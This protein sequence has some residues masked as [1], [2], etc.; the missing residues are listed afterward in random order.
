MGE[1]ALVDEQRLH[2]M[3]KDEE[4]RLKSV[5]VKWEKEKVL[6]EMGNL[7]PMILDNVMLN[8]SFYQKSK[9][10]KLK[11]LLRLGVPME[12][13]GKIWG[14][15]LHVSSIEAYNR[16]YAAGVRRYY[17]E[18]PPEH[19]IKHGL[20]GGKINHNLPLTPAGYRTAEM[21]LG[22]LEGDIHGLNYAPCLP[23][24]VVLLLHF[25]SPSETLGICLKVVKIGL[26]NNNWCY[27]PLTMKDTVLFAHV[28]VELVKSQIPQLSAHVKK[29]SGGEEGWNALWLELFN[30][31]FVGHL[32]LPSLVRLV[33]CLFFEGA[34]IFYR[35][36]LGVLK[37]MQK[38]LFACDSI[39]SLNQAIKRELSVSQDARFEELLTIGFSFKFARSYLGKLRFEN[40]SMISQKLL[41]LSKIEIPEKPEL[42]EPST[43]M[44]DDDLVALWKTVPE[45]FKIKNLNLV[46]SSRKQGHSLLRLYENTQVAPLLMII[47]T[48]EG[49]KFGAYL[50]H[51]WR[52]RKIRT[53]FGGGEC[54]LFKLGPDGCSVYPWIKL[55]KKNEENGTNQDE[56]PKGENEHENKDSK[57][58]PDY[59]MMGDANFMVVGGGGGK[60]GLWVDSDLRFGKTETCTTFNNPPLCSKEQF[61]IL[62]VEVY[63]FV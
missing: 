53:F 34:K 17:G 20:F 27:I 11:K 15:V 1:A 50:S 2:Q 61:E 26:G 55:L 22:I 31:M 36:G 24:L 42:S 49:E 58:I 39:A 10:Q 28:F 44:Q 51:S 14:M 43:L 62:V 29:L 35:V 33:D 60:F 8:S 45:K 19:N 52:E 4:E 41:E 12:Y 56:K 25:A 30:S 59:F 54:F 47:G 13:K 46:Y 40:S 16:D 63:S 32:P 21:I 9:L 18:N 48:M 57:V 7:V 3:I 38:Y 37:Q 23:S 6:D 5:K